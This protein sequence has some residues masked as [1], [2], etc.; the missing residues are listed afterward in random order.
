VTDPSRPVRAVVGVLGGWTAV[1]TVMLWSGDAAVVDDAPV[2]PVN[3]VARIAQP[4]IPADIWSPRAPARRVTLAL[5]DVD[6]P[7]ARG[8]SVAVALDEPVSTADPA[9]AARAL[10]MASASVPRTGPEVLPTLPASA[11]KRVSGSVWALSRSDGVGASLA[12]G[13][14]LGGS[15]VGGRIFYTPG[16]QALA[17]T[18]RVSAPLASPRGR[19]ASVGIALRGKNLGLI[20]EQRFALD[21]GARDAPSV[22]AYGGISEVK[23]GHGIRLD[24]YAQAGVVGIRHSQGFVDG[25]VRLETTVTEERGSRLSAGVALSGGAQPRVSRLDIGPQLVARL[26][27]GTTALRVSAEWR[28]R[29]AGNAAPGSGPAVTIGFDF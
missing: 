3:D 23:L 14:Q 9:V 6:E 17:L 25:A 24:G 15:Q 28:Q 10:E 21:K 22:T 19:E 20:V 29:I 26:P 8:H 18:A 27:V 16:P 2:L 12:N 13:G 1:R 4:L 11:V 7:V 5:D